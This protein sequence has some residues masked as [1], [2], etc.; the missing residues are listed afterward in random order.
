MILSSESSPTLP[1]DLNLKAILMILIFLNTQ[2]LCLPNFQWQKRFKL[3]C[4]LGL[5]EWPGS[6]LRA[7]TG[8]GDSGM[9][10]AAL[11]GS[12]WAITFSFCL[13]VS[14]LLVLLIHALNCTHNR[15]GKDFSLWRLFQKGVKSRESSADPIRRC[16]FLDKSLHLETHYVKPQHSKRQ[17]WPWMHS[18]ALAN[19]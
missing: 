1:R 13:R 15:T 3:E 9:V 5:M 8:S 10:W 17:S 18:V 16:A 2:H 7:L 12:A 11:R 19:A 14:Y 4:I 6:A